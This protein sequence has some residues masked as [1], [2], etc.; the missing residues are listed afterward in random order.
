MCQELG[1]RCQERTARLHLPRP[2]LQPKS[3]YLDHLQTD[4]PISK[5][6]GR[7]GG[8]EQTVDEHDIKRG[9]DCC[10]DLNRIKILQIGK[11]GKLPQIARKRDRILIC[12]LGDIINRV[13]EL[14]ETRNRDRIVAARVD[15]HFIPRY[16]DISRQGLGGGSSSVKGR[17][18]ACDALCLGAIEYC[19]RL[20]EL[21]VPVKVV[22]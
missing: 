17:K 3:G 8:E 13:V 16:G 15:C 20:D 2:R 10:W 12:G 18:V 5:R 6:R 19:R 9:V 7:R 4:Q 1:M 21:D 11:V 22:G 14:L